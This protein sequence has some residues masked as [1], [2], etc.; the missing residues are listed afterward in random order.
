MTKTEN[1]A[2]NRLIEQAHSRPLDADDA[3]FSSPPPRK[4]SLPRPFPNRITP[5][6]EPAPMPRHRIPSSTQ[7]QLAAAPP[8][9]KQIARPSDLEDSGL[10]EVDDDAGAD[11]DDD[12]PMTVDEPAAV[13]PA[14]VA[15]MRAAAAPV[16]IA[17]IKPL[18]DESNWYEESLGVDRLDEAQLGTRFVRR[19][20]RTKSVLLLCGAFIT[21]LVATAYIAWPGRSPSI[22]PE[23]P[24][25]AAAVAAVTPA[26]PTTVVEPAVAAAPAAEPA[27]VPPAIDTTAA[28][29]T[30]VE[31]TVVEPVVT[32]SAEPAVVAAVE[33]AAPATLAVELDSEPSGATVLLVDGATTITLG[34]T[35]LSHELDASRSYELMFTMSG[36]KSA[37]VTVDPA[38]SQRVNVDLTSSK[39]T[40]APRAAEVVAVEPAVAAEPAVAK[41]KA[42]PKAAAKPAAKPARVARIDPPRPAAGGGGKGGVLAIGSK[43]PCDIFVDGKAT[44]LKTPQRELKLSPGPHKITLVNKD[45]KITETF[46]VDVKAGAPTKV[47]KDLTKRMK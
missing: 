4:S 36:H 40:S 31:P 44:R 15:P 14:A 38:K 42:K 34:S 35:P 25:P 30:V 39:A 9:Q 26:Q 43:P 1:T 6:D 29:P 13:A 22:A 41:S 47:V 45:H 32:P 33:P 24:A 20:S 23:T 7:T 28:A 27:V 10:L 8:A 18:S 37:L 3:L 2:V 12:M 5:V 16:R 21:G 11:D 19:S 17:D 46:T